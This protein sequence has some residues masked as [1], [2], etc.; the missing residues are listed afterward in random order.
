MTIKEFFNQDVTEESQYWLGWVLGL[1][2]GLGV[3]LNIGIMF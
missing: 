1:T 2:M 3:G